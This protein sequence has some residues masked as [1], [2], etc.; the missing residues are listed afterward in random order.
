MPQ[1]ASDLP[2]IGVLKLDTAFERFIGDIGNP[3]TLPYPV[4]L[5]TVSGATAAKVTT[6][7]GDELLAPFIDAGHRLI[8]RGADAITTT[9]G[10]LALYQRE[11]AAALPVPVATSSLL[12]VTFVRSVLPEGK[13]PGV[14]TFNAKSLGRKHLTA[15]GAPPDTP[16]VGLDPG[17]AMF[18]DILGQGRPT[19]ADER[20]SASLAAAAELKRRVPNLGAVVVECTN[21][22]PY[23]AAIARALGVPVFD[24]ITLIEW[25]A[26]AV[27]PHV[28]GEPRQRRSA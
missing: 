13:R 20:E 3:G 14:L 11:L 24:T 18:L 2:T 15:V 4:L 28:Y 9:C 10:F 17:S 6:L 16:I 25:L 19:T 8:G 1:T 27:R 5:E 26:T 12:Q 21:I 7:E 22:A 23:S